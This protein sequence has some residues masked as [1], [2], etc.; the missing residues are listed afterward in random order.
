MLIHKVLKICTVIVR[1]EE[2]LA[3]R[4]IKYGKL[5]LTTPDRHISLKAIGV[6]QDG[7]YAHRIHVHF[8]AE[9]DVKHTATCKDLV[10][11]HSRAFMEITPGDNKPKPQIVAR[12]T[13]FIENKS[14]TVPVEVL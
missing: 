9:E 2:E 3:F 10:A 11:T 12:A 4:E 8:L 6:I 1:S 14:V 7:Q 5:R 13:F